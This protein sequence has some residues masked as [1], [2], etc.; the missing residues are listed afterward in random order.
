MKKPYR[1]QYGRFAKRP[2][3]KKRTTRYGLE[4]FIFFREIP[5]S[6][7]PPLIVVR[8]P[9][10]DDIGSL[11][12]ATRQETIQAQHQEEQATRKRRPKKE[13]KEWEDLNDILDSYIEDMGIDEDGIGGS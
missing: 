11:R 2:T 3:P 5:E 10:R 12:P 1:D 13:P 8:P 6:G 7:D 9:R 4:D